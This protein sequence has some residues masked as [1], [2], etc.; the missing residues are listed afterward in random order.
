MLSVRR[1]SIL[2]TAHKNIRCASGLCFVDNNEQTLNYLSDI[3]DKEGLCA[4]RALSGHEA[5]KKYE[6]EKRV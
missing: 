5:L 4:I 2:D 3:I 6:E 1:Q